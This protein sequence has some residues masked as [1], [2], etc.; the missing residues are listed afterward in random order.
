[1]KG[2]GLETTYTREEIEWQAVRQWSAWFIGAFLAE[3]DIAYERYRTLCLERALSEADIA[4]PVAREVYQCVRNWVNEAIVTRGS[5]AAGEFEEA[6]EVLPQWLTILTED[7]SAE[8]TM[9]RFDE[10]DE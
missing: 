10:E 8:E 2:R 7:L 9:R 5:C 4:D 1:V 6:L 3:P